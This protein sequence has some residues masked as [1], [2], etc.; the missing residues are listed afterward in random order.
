[1][2]KTSL[3]FGRWNLYFYTIQPTKLWH[4]VLSWRTSDQWKTC[5]ETLFFSLSETDL[6]A[7]GPWISVAFP[8]KPRGLFWII[9][10]GHSCSLSIFTKR[11]AFGLNRSDTFYRVRSARRYNKVNIIL[12]RMRFR[13]SF[14][15]NR[16]WMKTVLFKGI[17]F[18]TWLFLV[19]LCKNLG[20]YI[21][22]FHVEG[23]F[24]VSLRHQETPMTEK[25]EVNGSQTV[26]QLKVGEA[27]M[28]LG[29][30]RGP[31][32]DAIP[33]VVWRQEFGTAAA[34][35]LKDMLCCKPWGSIETQDNE[36]L[37]E[38]DSIPKT[39]VSYL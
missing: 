3:I 2:K 37:P 36:S 39:K 18:K 29:E 25:L 5:T 20:G 10:L 27:R 17:S 16:K 19:S 31:P 28:D 38:A 15:R 13:D 12:W 4:T 32:D 23:F 6:R 34:I 8:E 22:K 21:F 14:F 30:F 11:F 1:M 26:H 24:G 9:T 7:R 35:E 33:K